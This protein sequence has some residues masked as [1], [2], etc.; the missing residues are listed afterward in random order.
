MLNCIS[1]LLFR[2]SSIDEKTTILAHSMIK[3][4]VFTHGLITALDLVYMNNSAGIA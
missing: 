1:K 4:G 2:K 3:Y